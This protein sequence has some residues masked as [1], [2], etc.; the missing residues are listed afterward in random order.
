MRWESIPQCGNLGI[1][2]VIDL[3]KRY[4]E[5]AKKLGLDHIAKT[6][7]QVG[8]PARTFLEALQFF[9]IL[10]FTLW[11]EGEYHNGVGRFDQYMLHSS[12]T[13]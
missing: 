7:E 8:K 1:D 4:R 5:E 3:A 10:H 6:L 11:C 13:T 12:N 9:R 2:A